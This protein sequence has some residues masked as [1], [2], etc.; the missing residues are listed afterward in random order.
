MTELG[1]RQTGELLAT[2]GRTESQTL[3][4][5][6]CAELDRW[7]AMRHRPTAIMA[8]EV[9][10]G[11]ILRILQSR[12]IRVPEDVSLFSLSGGTEKDRLTD[13]FFSRLDIPQ[14]DMA[15]VAVNQLLARID[16]Y[17]GPCEVIMLPM[18]FVE[19]K[20]VAPPSV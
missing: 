15:V 10:L 20:S 1:V 2:P 7:W 13:P 14:K 18:G 19:S 4:D 11:P 12:G 3:E 9:Y 5:I 17:D 6:C 16:G 8:T